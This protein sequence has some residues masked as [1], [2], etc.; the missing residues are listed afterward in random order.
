MIFFRGELPPR[1][2]PYFSSLSALRKYGRAYEKTPRLTWEISQKRNALRRWSISVNIRPSN[3]N[4]PAG[5]RLKEEHFAH[6]LPQSLNPGPALRRPISE[7]T[8]N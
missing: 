2:G 7:A 1:A 6:I 8:Y 3:R 5:L 4:G